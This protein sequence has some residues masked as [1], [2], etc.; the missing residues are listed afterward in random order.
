MLFKGTPMWLFPRGN[1]WVNVQIV[2]NEVWVHHRNLISTPSE[3]INILPKEG[4]QLF[5]LLQRQLNADSKVPITITV[6][7]NLL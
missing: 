3:H 7:D 5:L 1:C 2:T 6:Y 4:N